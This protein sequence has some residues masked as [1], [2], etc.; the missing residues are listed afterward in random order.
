MFYLGFADVEK[1]TCQ[2][3]ADLSLMV[4]DQLPNCNINRVCNI[5]R[6]RLGQ[7]PAVPVF[8]L[9]DLRDVLP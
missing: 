4:E 9:Q 2:Y 6:I 8:Y 1:L 5:L 3:H 7:L